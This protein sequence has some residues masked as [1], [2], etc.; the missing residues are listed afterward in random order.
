MIGILEYWNIGILGKI[1]MLPIAD[2]ASLL[3]R[4]KA[5]KAGK[6]PWLRRLNKNIKMNL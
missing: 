6:Q 4:S 3:R 2:F 5:T 1:G